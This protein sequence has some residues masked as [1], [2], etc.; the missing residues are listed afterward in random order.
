MSALALRPGDRIALLEERSSLAPPLLDAIVERGLTLRLIAPWGGARPGDHPALQAAERVTSGR[1]DEPGLRRAL[2]AC[3]LL[4]CL[5]EPRGP[6]PEAVIQMRQL[7]RACRETEIKRLVL[8][9]CATMLG[10]P[11]GAPLRR[12]DH[13]PERPEAKRARLRFALELERARLAA[14]A[15]DIVALYPGLVLTCRDD[16]R[17]AAALWR[18]PADRLTAAIGRRAFADAVFAAADAGRGRAGAR[19]ALAQCNASVG[20][21][22]ALMPRPTASLRD[23]RLLR[24]EDLL[25]ADV[26]LCTRAARQQ[27][28]LEPVARPEALS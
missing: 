5:I 21:L 6:L 18:A 11:S 24:E 23:R 2:S 7:A 3:T 15:L 13:L 19:Y 14:D 25:A 16:L 12:E 1:L 27:L 8:V 10:R 22:R 26:T 20:E 17:L 4:I 9:S 28:G